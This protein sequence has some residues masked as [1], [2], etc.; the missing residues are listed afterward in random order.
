[1]T[2]RPVSAYT[3]L[4]FTALGVLGFQRR[5]A[6]LGIFFAGLAHGFHGVGLIVLDAD[7]HPFNASTFWMMRAPEI[8]LIRMLQHQPVVGRQVRLALRAVEHQGI[9]LFASGYN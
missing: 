7:H 8:I 5:N 6:E 1:M 3:E 2:V 9:H 4:L